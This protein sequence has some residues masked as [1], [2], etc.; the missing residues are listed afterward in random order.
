MNSSSSLSVGTYKT[1]P[2]SVSTE[3][4]NGTRSS[5]LRATG[6]L[7]L[8]ASSARNRHHGAGSIPPVIAQC[9]N[10]ATNIPDLQL[11]PP[12]IPETSADQLTTVS[13]EQHAMHRVVQDPTNND[14]CDSSVSL[15]SSPPTIRG[16]RIARPPPALVR[17][18]IPNV[19]LEATDRDDLA[20]LPQ[21]SSTSGPHYTG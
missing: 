5:I 21:E 11:T 13:E 17:R 6:V 1:Q 7:S 12:S 2:Q 10:P 14:L 8:S 20:G 3:Q 16:I 15:V 19:K 18:S 9:S 4:R